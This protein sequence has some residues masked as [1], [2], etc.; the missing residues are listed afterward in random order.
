MAEELKKHI[1][2]ITGISDMDFDGIMQF[3]KPL[4][5]PKKQILLAEGKTCDQSY[6]VVKG[7]LRMFFINEKGTEQTIQFALEN[8]WLADYTSLSLHTPSGFNIQTVEKSELLSL[9]FASQ[10]AMLK[11]FPKME[12][13]FR[14]IH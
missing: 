3:L 2:K 6:F 12:R 7:C 5:V 4:T 13:Y 11:A 8:W 9:D 1:E 10:E 14:L